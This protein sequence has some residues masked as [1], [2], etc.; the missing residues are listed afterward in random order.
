MT[1]TP[2]DYLKGIIFQSQNAYKELRRMLMDGFLWAV[3]SLP[4]GVFNPYSGVKTSI[5][6]LDRTRTKQNDEV[7]FVK[8]END[9]FG[10][11]A[12]RREIELNDLPEA[13]KIIEKWKRDHKVTDGKLA[14]AVSRKRILESPDISLSSDRYR[15]VAVRGTGGWPMVKL[16]DVCDFVRGVTYDKNDESS[17]LTDVAVLRANNINV[18]SHTLDLS[19]IKYLRKDVGLPAEKRLRKGDIFICTASGSKNHLGKVAFVPEDTF[20]YFGGFMGAVRSRKEILPNFLFHLMM[21]PAYDDFIQGLTAGVNINNLK[22]SDLLSFEIPLPPLAEQERLVV[23]LE[24]YRRVIESAR[25]ILACYKPTV[26]IDPK[27][28]IVKLGEIMK[29]SSGRALFAKNMKPGKYAVYGGNGINGRHDQYFVDAPI[30]VIGR[31]G[32]YCGAIHVTEPKSW[33]TD[34]ALYVTEYLRKVDQ[35]FLALMLEDLNLNRFAKVGGQPSVSQ[36]TVLSQAVCLPNPFLL[37][38]SNRW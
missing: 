16:G 30:L 5:L 34:N 28:P 37:Q 9:G 24:G 31:V 36:G 6:L 25:Q 27:W 22:G 7:L 33:V 23:E 20:F 26:H 19:D 35:D 3:V 29:L 11:G 14:H 17:V 10:L 15:A 12:Q 18:D 13:L 2:K 32:A 38:R 1:A 21:S 8:V 4:A